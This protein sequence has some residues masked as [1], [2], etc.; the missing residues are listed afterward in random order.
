MIKIFIFFLHRYTV[1]VFIP[2]VYKQMPAFAPEVYSV[3]EG[4][5]P[6]AGKALLA[7]CAEGGDSRAAGSA[8][9]VLHL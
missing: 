3:W 1:L 7:G 5:R 2:I 6:A 4:H 9:P 8:F